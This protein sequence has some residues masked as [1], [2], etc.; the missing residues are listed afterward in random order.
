MLLRL[1]I[2]GFFLAALMFPLS[3]GEARAEKLKVSENLKIGRMRA[4]IWPEYDD[5]GTL[6]VY[7]GRFIDDSNFPTL[8][9]F[10]I[11]KGAV[12][13]DACS[14]SPGG[15]HFCQLYDLTKGENYDTVQLT[16]PF[17]N[18][19]VSFHL[20]P[21]NLDIAKRQI[22]YT[23]K[24]NH[25]VGSMEVDIQQPLRSSDFAISPSGG[26]ASV[27]KNFNHFNYIVKDMMKGEDQ[28]FKIGY[29]KESRQPSVDAKYA[30][31]TGRTVWGSPY[32]TQRNVRTIIYAVFGTGL[33]MVMIAMF[34]IVKTRRRKGAA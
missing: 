23:I 18:F 13:N 9:D 29:V 26:K 32:D 3:G 16:L 20:P 8:T 17:S 28:T 19:Y 27:Q 22:E 25:P 34:W 12:I 1:L 14:L 4:M 6:V 5:P 11:P 21:V 2:L 7:D 30:S 10:L 24:T 15:Q 31:M 33:L